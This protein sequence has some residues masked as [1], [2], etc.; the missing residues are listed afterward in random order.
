MCL[1]MT[2]HRISLNTT[3]F[4]ASA[5]KFT[6]SCVKELIKKLMLLKKLMHT[7]EFYESGVPIF[8]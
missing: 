8:N 2:H 7:H 3:L 5:V 4:S 1:K 6:H